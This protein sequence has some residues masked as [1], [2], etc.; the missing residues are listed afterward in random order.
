MVR[1]DL[2]AASPG[3]I[4]PVDMRI[5]KLKSAPRMGV[6]SGARARSVGG[7]GPGRQAAAKTRAFEWT[8]G[9]RYIIAKVWCGGTTQG[10]ATEGAQHRRVAHLRVITKGVGMRVL[11]FDR[12]DGSATGSPDPGSGWPCAC[13]L[14]PGFRRHYFGLSPYR[15]S[16]V[17]L[18]QLFLAGSSWV[19]MSTAGRQGQGGEQAGPP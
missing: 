17:A 2:G 7:R 5:R 13:G 16:P 1:V 8:T 4:S 6:G 9:V 18:S 19:L 3:P 12:A 10:R 15:K 14:T 11:L